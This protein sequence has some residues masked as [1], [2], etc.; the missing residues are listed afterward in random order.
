[1]M[2]KEKENKVIYKFKV[3]YDWQGT[4]RGFFW[5]NIG[6]ATFGTILYTLLSLMGKVS[7]L[8]EDPVGF[9][10]FLVFVWAFFIGLSFLLKHLYLKDPNVKPP[11]EV[12]VYED[13]V[14]VKKGEIEFDQRFWDLVKLVIKMNDNKV[15]I[16]G[17]ADR[18][19]RWQF[20]FR[21]T[22]EF[23]SNEEFHRFIK[24]T[25]I[26]IKEYIKKRVKEMNPGIE[27]VET[28]KRKKYR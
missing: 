17:Y 10:G 14:H 28:D 15:A 7:T 12:T 18:W 8:E 2:S 25:F 4:V 19:T 16:Y 5:L 3:E 27:I 21:R 23:H 22:V 1:M 13:K 24:E 26:P 20:G 6:V 11:I 9:I